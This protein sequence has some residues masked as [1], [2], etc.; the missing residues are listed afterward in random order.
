MK[1]IINVLLNILSVLINM[2]VLGFITLV[3][4]LISSLFKVWNAE[5]TN[6]VTCIAVMVL[7]LALFSDLKK[8]NFWG[9]TGEKKEKE[10]ESSVGKQGISK[11]GKQD[12][13]SEEVHKAQQETQ[14]Q[15]MDTT[16]GN[17]LSLAFEIERLLR[18]A[19]NV[20]FQADNT[21]KMSPDKLV[22]K[23][24]ESGLLTENGVK[25]IDSIRYL[26]NMI[27]HG[28]TSELPES[29]LTAGISLAWSFYTE[30]YNWL[31]NPQ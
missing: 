17:F 29:T 19:A 7:L 22:K 23:L 8:F 11:T 31:Q 21:N 2:K 28:R 1:T 14:I 26:R 6:N 9:L 13:D 3:F 4:V 16:T 24:Q 25:Q 30:L 18:V 27:V 10:I 15:L 20:I 5:L 12:I